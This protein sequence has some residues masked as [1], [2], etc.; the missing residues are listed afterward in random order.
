[1]NKKYFE[2]AKLIAVSKK[3]RRSFLIGAIGIRNDGIIVASPNG[4][5]RIRENTKDR[6]YF[7]EAH[8]EFRI[9]R[10]L[11]V[12]ATVY[13][14]RVRRGDKKVC[15]AKPCETC[16]NIMKSRGVKK[17]YYSISEDENGIL[18][19]DSIYL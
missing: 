19:W 10:K 9:S 16:Q 18:K 2:M 6:G 5:A 12:G 1:M 3:D 4:P 15:L 8:A 11:D 7:P 14:I 13:V 17:V